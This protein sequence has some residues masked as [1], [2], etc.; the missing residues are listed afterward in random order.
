MEREFESKGLLSKDQFELL[1]SSLKVIE[2][3]E[4][5]NT[6]IDTADGFFKSKTSALRLRIINGQYIFSL[7]RQDADGATEWNC[8]FTKAEYD[9]TIAPREIDLAAYNCPYDQRLTELELVTISTTRYVC[10]YRDSIIELDA[11]SFGT[12]T[13]YE[14]EIEAEDLT[15]ASKIAQNLATEYQLDIKKSHP[16]IARFYMYN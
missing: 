2:T 1:I 13:D 3:R 14:L 15:T 5:V 4:Q 6:Y 11:T 9:Q 16:K 10:E 12:V 8:Q 7:K